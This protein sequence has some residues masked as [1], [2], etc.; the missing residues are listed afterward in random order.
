MRAQTLVK[1]C[2]I[3]AK[4]ET[5]TERTFQLRKYNWNSYDGLEYSSEKKMKRRSVS[6]YH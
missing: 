6:L 2:E 1:A 3:S 4:C 5:H